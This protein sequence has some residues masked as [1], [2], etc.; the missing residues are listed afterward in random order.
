M[1]D[2]IEEV[3]TDCPA[4]G[5]EIPFYRTVDR[6]KRCPECGKSADELFEIAIGSQPIEPAPEPDTE[7]ALTDGGR[8][9]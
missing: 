3:L 9:E 8:N 2:D 6:H 4:C 5:M 7:L 1:T